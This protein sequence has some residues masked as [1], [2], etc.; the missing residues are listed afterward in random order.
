MLHEMLLNEFRIHGGAKPKKAG[1]NI[2]PGVEL[3]GCPDK[4]M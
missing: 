4:L 3:A 2:G 1:T